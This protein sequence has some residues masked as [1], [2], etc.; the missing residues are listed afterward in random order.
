MPVEYADV[1]LTELLYS[2]EPSRLATALKDARIVQPSL[3]SIEY[4][5]AEVFE[6]EWGVR[7]VA[8]LGHSLGE[9]AAACVAGVLTLKVDCLLSP[10]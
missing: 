5:L 7:P 2:S 6:K 3:F 8:V 10:S 9:I 4:A 1:L